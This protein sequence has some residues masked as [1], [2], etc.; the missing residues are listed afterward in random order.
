M[1]NLE[2]LGDGYSV[3]LEAVRGIDPYLRAIADGL[4]VA[5]PL[6]DSGSAQ[7]GCGDSS[8]ATAL[9]RFTQA[10]DGLL[11]KSGKDLNAAVE[12]LDVIRQRYEAMENSVRFNELAD[13]LGLDRQLRTDRLSTHGRPVWLSLFV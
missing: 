12:N 7:Q 10:A 9:K 1:S 13:Q 8:L 11:D 3:E 2:A 6:T 5:R 4:Q